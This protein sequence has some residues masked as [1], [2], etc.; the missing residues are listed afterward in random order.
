MTG[1][2]LG[3]DILDGQAWLWICVPVVALLVV[4]WRWR[5]S[6][7]G[8]MAWV[9][10]GASL[11]AIVLAGGGSWGVSQGV[12]LSIVTTR[13][14]E[15]AGDVKDKLEAYE[16]RADDLEKLLSLLVAMTAVY[17]I[18]LGLT[19]YVQAKDSA[20]K[21]DRLTAEAF[22]RGTESATRLGTIEGQAQQEAAK[23]AAEIIRIQDTN[24][25]ALV[26]LGNRADEKFERIRIAADRQVQEFVRQVES[27]FPILADLAGGLRHMGATVARLF[28]DIDWSAVDYNRLHPQDK[29]EVLYYERAFAALEPFNLRAM[30]K[31]ASEIYHGLGNFYGLKYRT[32]KEE[33]RKDESKPAPIEDDKERARFYLEKSLSVDGTNVAAMNDRTFFALNIDPSEGEHK[34]AEQLCATSLKLDPEQQRARYNLAYLEHTVHSNYRLSNDLLT[35][36]LAKTKWQLDQPARRRFSILYNRACARCRLG[37]M[38]GAVV[39]LEEA[40]PEAMPSE[41]ALKKQ[42]VE[43]IPKIKEVLK[44]DLKAPEP[45]SAQEG[46]LYRLS[47][48]DPYRKRVEQVS[49]RLSRY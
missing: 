21:L 28:P 39:D 2:V 12:R 46:D 33:N 20:D 26:D 7:F 22:Q 24:L 43:D 41:D 49:A 9:L 32:E 8:P 4:I 1:G 3:F 31:E 36:A 30:R 38:E 16:K 42:F 6:F 48:T 10:V 23:L 18:A 37:D 14:G 47:V 45:T 5:R 29:Q 35:E 13:S 27:R 44:D 19:A 34:K 11:P 17:G 25:K 40:I 15:L